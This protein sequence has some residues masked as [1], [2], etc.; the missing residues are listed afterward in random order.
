VPVVVKM[1][2]KFRGRIRAQLRAVIADLN[3][4]LNYNSQ[5]PTKTLLSSGDITSIN[6][7]LN[8]FSLALTLKVP[9]T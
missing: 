4:I 9:K 2:F 8:D 7:L 1:V 6:T 3:R 5:H